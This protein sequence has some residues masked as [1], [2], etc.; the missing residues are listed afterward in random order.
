ME[1][2]MKS[3][4]ILIMAILSITAVLPSMVSAGVL[5]NAIRYWDPVGI[6][7]NITDI[8]KDIMIVKEQKVMLIN[9][10]LAGK[11]YVTKVMDINGGDVPGSA[12]KKGVFVVVKGSGAYDAASKSDVIVAKEIYVLPGE[13]SE[14]ELSRYPKLN[15]VADKW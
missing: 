1:D 14:K 6:Y 9:D 4:A 10:T 13:M 12:L 2:K 8:S 11:R 7:G 5:H 15:E 3:K